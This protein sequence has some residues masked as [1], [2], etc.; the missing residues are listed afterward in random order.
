MKLWVDTITRYFDKLPTQ[1]IVENT[2]IKLLEKINTDAKENT[3]EKMSTTVQEDD[4][5]LDEFGISE[6]ESMGLEWIEI[7]LR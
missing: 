3:F 7:L 4:K 5:E 6:S 1:F 2:Q